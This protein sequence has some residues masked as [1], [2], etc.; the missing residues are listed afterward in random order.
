MPAYCEPGPQPRSRRSAR[1]RS[2]TGAVLDLNGLSETLGALA[3]AGNVTLGSGTLTAGGNNAS[4]TYSGAISGSRGFNKAGTGTLTL[5]GTDSYTGVTNINGGTLQ[6]IGA[7]TSSSAV[8]VNAGGTL[9]GT[10]TVDPNPV[11]RQFWRHL[12]PGVPGV[13]GTRSPSPAMSRSSPA[14]SI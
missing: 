5:T 13:A 2:A 1:S 4:T 9:A 11:D 10:G 12:S 7:I 8:N 14:R 6:V 3:G